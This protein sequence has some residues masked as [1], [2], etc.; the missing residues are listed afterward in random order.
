MPT[1]TST[2][3]SSSSSF[4]YPSQPHAIADALHHHQLQKNHHH[5]HRH[6]GLDKREA[7]TAANSNDTFFSFA[8]NYNYLPRNSISFESNK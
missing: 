3:M 7:N 1:T 8:A 5:P 4:N 6:N 2:A